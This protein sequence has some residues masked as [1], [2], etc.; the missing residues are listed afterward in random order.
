MLALILPNGEL[1]P[2]P[3]LSDLE[4]SMLE[5]TLS[6]SPPLISKGF[7]SP[8]CLIPADSLLE[9][10]S[11]DCLGGESLFQRGFVV[12]QGQMFSLSQ[13]VDILSSCRTMRRLPKALQL[14]KVS[15]PVVWL[16][17]N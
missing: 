7:F 12:P 6:P 16:M 3:L 15:A 10:D 13:P 11:S 5:S 1:F 9:T 14:L 8:S 2:E 4:L 17:K